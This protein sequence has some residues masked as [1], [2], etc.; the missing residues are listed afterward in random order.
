[1]PEAA[2]LENDIPRSVAIVGNA[3]DLHSLSSADQIDAAE[4]VVRFNNASGFGTWSGKRVTHLALVNHGGQ[5]EEWLSDATFV[6][7][8]VVQQASHILFPFPRKTEN[9]SA[10]EKD[11]RDWTDAAQSLLERP[12][13]SVTILPGTVHQSA[14]QLLASSENRVPTPS[15][16]FL[17]ALFLLGMLPTQTRIDV[18]GFGFE[19]W[20]GHSWM[21][22][23]RWFEEQADQGR[24]TLHS[25]PRKSA[26]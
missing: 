15:T 8:P 3:P 12:K 14:R 11:G 24:L 10:Q 6:Q 7:R 25:L 4:W 23:K 17:V 20:S 19:G 18:H 2:A 26:S 5:M 1:M 9:P 21:E 13:V 22:E 16:G